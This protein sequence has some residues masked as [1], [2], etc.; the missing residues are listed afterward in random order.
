M[1]FTLAKNTVLK[2]GAPSGV[3]ITGVTAISWSGTSFATEDTT[4]HD[5]STPVKT[6]Q[7]TVYD[8]GKLTL[9]IDYDGTN[10]Q[11]VALKTLSTSGAAQQFEMIQVASAA[12]NTFT[13]FV[14]SFAFVTDVTGLL[15]AKVDI[16][17]SG[18]FS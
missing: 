18:A 13:G 4:N 11:H 7:T 2:L 9:T 5:S 15:K 3:Q 8:N 10:T 6:L 12:D 17:N 1:A 14:T 16:S